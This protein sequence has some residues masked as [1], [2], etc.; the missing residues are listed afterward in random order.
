MLR[1]DPL[2]HFLAVGGILFALLSWFDSEPARDEILIPA[3]RVSELA[4]TAELLQGRPP[5]PGELERLVADAIRE[6]VYYR[7]GLALGLDV[8]DEIVRQRLIEKMRELTE[9]V[10]DPLPPDADLAA[11]FESNRERFRIPE[12]VSFDHVFFSPS[13]RGDDIEADA[14]EALAALRR[15]ADP[16]DFGDSTP[17][18]GRFEA[19]DE[20]RVRTLFGEPLTSAVFGADE[21]RW[22]G[23]FESGFGR[24]LVRV[25]ARSAARDPAFAEVEE[26]VRATYAAE[27]LARANAAAFDEM[28]SQFE[29]SVQWQPDSA[30]ETWP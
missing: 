16:S 22:I 21:G 14:G 12:L 25:T 3:E 27:Q 4:R 2:V 5:T 1:N 10:V 20:A 6:E 18:S 30:P 13:A 15:G 7:E 19:A 8:D 11:W 9:N 29:I 26:R 17:L 28:R 23:P 24:H